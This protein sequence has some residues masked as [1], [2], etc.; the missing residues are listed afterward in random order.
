MPP[1]LAELIDAAT[2][3]QGKFSIGRKFSAGSVA[4]ALRTRSGTVYTG[5]CLDL[6]CG[7]G[8][9][10]EHSAVAEMLKAR[11]TAIDAVVAVGKRGVLAP[12][13]RCRELMVQIDDANLDARVVLRGGRVV[14]LR[15][16]LPEHWLDT[17]AKA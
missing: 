12:C 13:G 1:D 5:V 8:F 4:A 10:A 16:L 14:P 15:D 11:E 2:R 17:I 6:A 7:I 3:A 9:C